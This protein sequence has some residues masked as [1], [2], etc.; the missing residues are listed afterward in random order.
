MLEGM[1]HYV[2]MIVFLVTCDI[3]LTLHIAILYKR[4]NAWHDSM[5]LNWLPRRII[6]GNPTYW[7]GL[8]M[9]PIFSMIYLGALYLGSML[10]ME[11]TLI[12]G[13]FLGALAVVNYIHLHNLQHYYEVKEDKKYWAFL[14]RSRNK[15][16]S[17]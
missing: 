1:W 10:D 11:L 6:N 8:F 3:M 14:R 17:M 13:I 12:V 5:E 16:G 15:N 4:K 9:V 2:W 7:K